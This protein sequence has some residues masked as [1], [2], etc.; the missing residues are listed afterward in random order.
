MKK[1]RINW[2]IK[3]FNIEHKK[4]VVSFDYPIQRAGEQWDLLQKSLLI[5][6][7]AC[8]YPVPPLYSLSQQEVVGKGAK[9][10]NMKVYY[11]LDGKQRLT[12][13]RDFVELGYRLDA[14]T[15][16]F[17]ID[18]VSHNFAK[19]RFDELPEEIKDAIQSF[20]LDIFELEE[21]TD[22]E[23][24]DMFFRLNNGTPL[25]SLQKAKA[26]MGSDSAIKLQTIAS[27]KLMKENASFTPL[28]IRK[29]DDETALVQAMMLLDKEYTVGKF[30]NTDVFDYS[31]TLRTGKD[32]VFA[33]IKIALD[34]LN[35]TL[36]E[37]IEKTLLKKL[38][39]PFVI[40]A[41]SQALQAEI[42]TE[43]FAEWLSSFKAK[44]NSKENAVQIAGIPNPKPEN[45]WLYKM[46]CGAGAT[47][48]EKVSD[49]WSATKGDIQEFINSVSD[50]EKKPF[51]TTEDAEPIIEE[52]IVESVV[53]TT[54]EDAEKSAEPVVTTEQDNT[55]VENNEGAEKPADTATAKTQNRGRQNRGNRQKPQAVK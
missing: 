45:V 48:A 16:P 30:G 17:V 43:R 27:H 31:T 19:F 32:E 9:A 24:E 41:S 37:K 34:Y 49:R 40:W 44:I 47:K 8:D 11:I 2:T 26:K 51:V 42:P 6:S 23:I 1:S 4:G 39:M 36:G 18:G 7:I 46:G 20:T 54:S 5:H 13:I 28:Q 50:S 25:S 15:P 35:E 29:A 38:H 14:E 53:E 21:C 22:D 3:K 12:N 55:T 33:D 52:T 10:K